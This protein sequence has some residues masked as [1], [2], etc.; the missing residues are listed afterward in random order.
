MRPRF[1]NQP[2]GNLVVSL[3]AAFGI[4]AGPVLFKASLDHLF[5]LDTTSWLILISLIL[6]QTALTT[7]PGRLGRSLGLSVLVLASISTLCNIMNMTLFK[8]PVSIIT[9]STTVQSNAQEVSEFLA[10]Y[11]T[12]L[13]LSAGLVL[14]LAL[15]L[16]AYYRKAMQPRTLAVSLA[17]L[18][19]SFLYALPSLQKS[20]WNL[21]Q[22]AHDFHEL[23]YVDRLFTT[24]ARYQGIT[25]AREKARVFWSQRVEWQKN[26]KLQTSRQTPGIVIVVIGESTTRRHMGI[27]GY[28]RLTTPAL[29]SLQDQ[30]IVFPDA[31]SP[32]ASTLQ[33]VIGALCATGFHMESLECQG[34]T[35][36]EIARAAG[37]QTTWISNQAPSG[38][39][40]N[41]IV[42]LGRTADRTI[43]VNQDV[44]S[45][46]EA[47]NS[48]SL[49][50]KVLG[51]LDELLA[52]SQADDTKHMI[53][54]HLM[55]THFI[56][57]KRYPQEKALFVNTDDLALDSGI[58]D[59]KARAIINH[60]DN[61]VAYQ[62]SVLGEMMDRLN[63]SDREGLLFY[64]S[65]HGEEVYNTDN[66]AGHSED[67]VTPAMREVPV[68]V[69]F[70]RAYAQTCAD[71]LA[72][73][74]RYAERP[75]STFQ[76][77]PS[78]AGLL[79]LQSDA[80]DDRD[81]IFSEQFLPDRGT[82]RA[83]SASSP[84]RPPYLRK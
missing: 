36:I 7:M 66:F 18:A 53:F 16:L 76:L 34:P 71:E 9:L 20:D 84:G 73:W 64:F 51:P 68:I 46:G 32:I 41:F 14:S 58:T 78:I 59:P 8:S 2:I 70:S 12:R 6:L 50:E 28:E 31:I 75:F 67:R 21:K 23:A 54:V 39:G 29:E 83:S 38:F 79:G 1:W 48:A 82:M 57:E 69:G 30:L 45:A 43:F 56:Y 33:G 74:R 17:C 4:H 49:D 15:P 13:A 63:A 55:G 11:G 62:D 81:N 19:L 60:Y 44:S 22:V 52:T 77:T 35:L 65:D 5:H 80:F 27:Y 61:A 3:L 40:D 26:L 72:Q 47:D 10:L 24:M 42:E 37:Y 25:K